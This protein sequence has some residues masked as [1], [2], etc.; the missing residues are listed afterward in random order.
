MSIERSN[1]E[2]S[3]YGW[4][5]G[6]A[7]LKVCRIRNTNDKDII[8]AVQ[9]KCKLWKGLN[10]LSQA[11]KE[12]EKNWSFNDNDRHFF[13]MT[14]E[15]VDYFPSRNNGVKNILKILKTIFGYT[16]K[17]YS[18][19]STFIKPS[20][21][22][23]YR[24]VASSNWHATANFVSTHIDEG[25]L[26]DIGS[27]TTDLIPIKDGAVITEK[28]TSDDKRLKNGELVYL[29]ITRTSISSI[30][31][32]LRFLN[33]SY[34]VMR[35]SFANTADVFR[36][37]NELEPENDLY[38]TC[39]TKEKT[40]LASERRLARVIGM[41]RENATSKEW[42]VF[43]NHIKT[44]I[45]KELIKNIKKVTKRFNL[46]GHSPLI[47]TGSGAFLAKQLSMEYNKKYY[48]FHEL[49]ANDFELKDH[50]IKEVNICAPAV[51]L[52]IIAS[53][54]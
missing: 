45:I 4:D 18:Q 20:S 15:M 27:T 1:K 29:G 49:V 8:R 24:A 34:N 33:C 32:T 51:S 50:Q 31:P 14:G 48:M 13:T 40:L 47:I 53:R 37:T 6:G 11:I 42:R 28:I 17:C 23:S 25:I 26:V 54:K 10:H 52:A 16:V 2:H 22:N 35:E 7:H 19:D 39:D 38:P 41:D 12:V 30:K 44:I 46:S 3:F 21:R 5:I 43:A 36:I 9:I